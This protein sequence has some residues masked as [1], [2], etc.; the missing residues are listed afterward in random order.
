M[1][2]SLGNLAQSQPAPLPNE[3][4]SLSGNPAQIQSF[5]QSLRQQPQAGSNNAFMNVQQPQQPVQANPLVN[6]SNLNPL[7]NKGTLTNIGQTFQ[8]PT[9]YSGPY[10]TP[11]T[12]NYKTGDGTFADKFATDN[13]KHDSDSS[14]STDTTTA[15]KSSDYQ[16][17]ANDD[18]SDSTDKTTA[19]KTLGYQK[20]ANDDSGGSTD[21]TTAAKTL[22]YQ[23]PPTYNPPV[24]NPIDTHFLASQT[25]GYHKPLVYNP[26][27]A[28]NNLLSDEDKK[29]D[30]EP[31][32]KTVSDFIKSLGAHSYEYKNPKHGEGRFVSPMAQE[33]E[34]TDVGKSAVVDTPEGK[35]VNYGRL[36]GITL[37][38]V[39]M[40]NKRLDHIEQ[41]FI[42]GYK[43]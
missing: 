12:Q 39:A 14:D 8:N 13:V 19:A 4:Q 2:N 28:T 10:D 20:P 37:A 32:D 23:K 7:G 24:Y 42:K 27:I 18:S 40:I 25:L 33:L 34:K 1:I 11:G 43:K 16:K 31:A 29:K 30:I 22:G 35:M 41:Q 9:T 21:T 3:Q 38:A 5:L 36:G 15:A 26:P 6:T 17:P